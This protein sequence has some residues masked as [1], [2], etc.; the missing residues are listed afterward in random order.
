MSHQNGSKK[1]SDDSETWG[2]CKNCKW[3]QIEPKDSVENLTM[4]LRIEEELQ[5]FRLRVSGNSGCNCF[6]SGKVARAEGS[7]AAPPTAKV[8]R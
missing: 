2:L 1:H 5:P 6:M 3:W 8:T 4:G 7:G